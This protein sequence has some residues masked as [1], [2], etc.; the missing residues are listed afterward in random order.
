MYDSGGISFECSSKTSKKRKHKSRSFHDGKKLFRV[1]GL[2]F[3]N[4]CSFQI[5]RQ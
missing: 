1:E 4:K 5:T 3:N 2:D